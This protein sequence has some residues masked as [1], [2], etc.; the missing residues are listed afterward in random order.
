M[1]T[2]ADVRTGVA[3]GGIAIAANIG[4]VVL[5]AS[6]RAL[7]APAVAILA[8]VAASKAFTA[9]D[10]GPRDD[11]L[12]RRCNQAGQSLVAVAIAEALMALVAGFVW[13]AN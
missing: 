1:S 10:N 13:A 6:A 2:A 5:G 9:A 4:G 8:A 3:A 11:E 7:I 12:E